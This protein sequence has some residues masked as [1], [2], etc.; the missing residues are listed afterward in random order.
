MEHVR[1]FPEFHRL[2]ADL[3]FNRDK[4]K[5]YSPIPKIGPI[6]MF[7]LEIDDK[8]K[9]EDADACFIVLRSVL[10]GLGM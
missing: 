9:I 7:V 4:R 5:F 2:T 1:F 10:L 8:F 6:A 3:Y